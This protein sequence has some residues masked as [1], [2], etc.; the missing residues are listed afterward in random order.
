MSKHI[1]GIVGVSEDEPP[2]PLMQIK[3]HRV[4]SQKFCSETWML[5]H[6]DGKLYHAIKKGTLSARKI[7]L[8]LG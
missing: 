1:G 5:A 4:V 7:V 6:K 2:T 3:D 8:H